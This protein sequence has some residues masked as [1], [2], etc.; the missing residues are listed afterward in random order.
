[1]CYVSKL[2]ILSN[3]DNISL[4]FYLI[5]DSW[6]YLSLSKVFCICYN[7]ILIDEIYWS[8]SDI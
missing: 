8:F 7:K 4:D 3:S 2:F 5:K 1:L 6:F